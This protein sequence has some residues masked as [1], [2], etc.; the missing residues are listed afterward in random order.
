MDDDPFSMV[1]HR[2][3]KSKILTSHCN[4]TCPAARGYHKPGRPVRVRSRRIMNTSG[5]GSLRCIS[6]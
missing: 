3:D 4:V 1:S 5:I 2:V 6:Y